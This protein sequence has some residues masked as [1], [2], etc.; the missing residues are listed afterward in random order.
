MLFGDDS[1]AATPQT[2]SGALGASSVATALAVATS[3][4]FRWVGTLGPNLNC[5]QSLC[6]E[7]PQRAGVAPALPS[8]HSSPC[9]SLCVIVGVCG[10]GCYAPTGDR[11]TRHQRD[12]RCRSRRRTSPASVSV[13]TSDDFE[14]PPDRAGGRCLAAKFPGSPS[15]QSG[16]AGQLTSV[17]TRGLSSEH[18]QVLIDGIPINQGLAG[19]FNFADLSIDN[20]D[21]IEIVRGPQSTLYGPRALAGVIQLF[22]KQG[23]GPPSR[24]DQCRGR[25]LRH[26]RE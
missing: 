21:H 12:T 17:F 16:T 4:S 7:A 20:I 2:L 15:S 23:N 6:G 18:T 19:F 1:V 9:S 26:F 25:H 10:A 14:D 5:F 13:I 8:R 11:R 22:T 24:L 3:F